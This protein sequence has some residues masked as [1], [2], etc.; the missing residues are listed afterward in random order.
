MDDKI[1]RILNKFT[2]YIIDMMDSDNEDKLSAAAVW[3]RFDTDTKITMFGIVSHLV[4]SKMLKDMYKIIISL[5]DIM[6]D[7][8]E[9]EKE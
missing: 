3:K 8:E 7:L 9:T 4:G 2:D 1:E 6:Q 5:K